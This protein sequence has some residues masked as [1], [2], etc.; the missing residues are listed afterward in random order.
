MTVLDQ[1]KKRDSVRDLQAILT[2][3]SGSPVSLEDA[4]EA[5]NNLLAIVHLLDR[6]D[7]RCQTDDTT[8]QGSGTTEIG[9]EIGLEMVQKTD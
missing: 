3:R 4:N 5:A 1:D 7:R 6:I 9:P 8:N 2:R